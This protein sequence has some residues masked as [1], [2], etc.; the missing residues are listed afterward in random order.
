MK[1][2]QVKYLLPEMADYLP[3]EDKNIVNVPVVATVVS[4]LVAAGWPKVS[5]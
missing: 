1:L 3:S 2:T 5:K 4:D